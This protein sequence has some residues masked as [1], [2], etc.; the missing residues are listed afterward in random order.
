M[1]KIVIFILFTYVCVSV[2]GRCE[3]ISDFIKKGFKLM[4]LIKIQHA[5]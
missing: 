3:F 4:P 2:L 5:C 1:V